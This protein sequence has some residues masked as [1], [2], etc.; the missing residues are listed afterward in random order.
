[1]SLGDYGIIFKWIDD[2]MKRGQIN[3]AKKLARLQKELE[4]VDEQ[5]RLFKLKNDTDFALLERLLIKQRGL[6]KKIQS[7]VR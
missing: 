2:L 6:S 7:F 5:I 1:M 3:R 4:D